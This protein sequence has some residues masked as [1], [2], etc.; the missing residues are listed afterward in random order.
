MFHAQIQHVLRLES[1]QLLVGMLEF[2]LL[3]WQ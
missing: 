1:A 2:T 3:V